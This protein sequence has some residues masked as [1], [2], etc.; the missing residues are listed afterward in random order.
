[1]WP[2]IT[3]AGIG[4]FVMS[5]LGKWAKAETWAEIRTQAVS[6]LL[7][8]L[9][10][11][12]LTGAAFIAGVI[13][14]APPL[15]WVFAASAMVFAFAVF[16]VLGVKTMLWMES[17]E[18]KLR[19]SGIIPGKRFAS[20]R[21]VGIKYGIQYQN[22]AMF[23]IDF[24]LTPLR[25]SLGGSINPNPRRDITGALAQMGATGVF[26]EAEVPMTKDM[27]GQLVEGQLEVEIDYGRPGK[28]RFKLVKKYKTYVQFLPSGD[29]S[30]FESSEVP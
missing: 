23:P 8:I 20:K 12:V 5:M 10:P 16:G 17:P 14:G 3:V 24:T 13:Q 28:K 1:M 30:T 6:G 21:L 9:W 15:V 19:F 2:Y 25:V 11:A 26:W 27:K 4:R 22:T 29:T 7:H 18:N